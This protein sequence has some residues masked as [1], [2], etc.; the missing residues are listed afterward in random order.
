MKQDR[1]QCRSRNTEH[2]LTKDVFDQ[3]PDIFASLAFGG[4]S[5]NLGLF[6]TADSFSDLYEGL[7]ELVDGLLMLFQQILF[8]EEMGRYVGQCG[9]AVRTWRWEL[10]EEEVK[11]GSPS[12][13]LCQRG[14]FQAKH[15]GH[16][17]GD[18]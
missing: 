4:Q 11:G 16:G 12:I 15:F 7:L 18:R 1:K 8:G 6:N 2:L 17:G 3:L 5:I 13:A 14:G 9:G 10:V